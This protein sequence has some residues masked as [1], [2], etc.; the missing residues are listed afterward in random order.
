MPSS[1]GSINVMANVLVVIQALINAVRVVI[2]ERKITVAAD[3]T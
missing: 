2:I 1:T 3:Y